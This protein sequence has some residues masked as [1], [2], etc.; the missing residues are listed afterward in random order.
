MRRD[1]S[2]WVPSNVDSGRLCPVAPSPGVS[3]V[4]NGVILAGVM[5]AAAAGAAVRVN[6][7]AASTSSR[8]LQQATSNQV[9]VGTGARWQMPAFNDGA[10]ES[11][12]GP[13]GFG[14]SF[15]TNLDSRMRTKAVSLYLRTPFVVDAGAAASTGTVWLT[16]DYDD[17]FV[18]ALNGN[19]ILRKNLG[20]P[21]A[22]VFRDQA[23]FNAHPMGTNVTVALGRS[24]DLFVTGTNW[25]TVQ[26]HNE[27]F[28][29]AD[30]G[31]SAAL[32][33]VDGVN[34]QSLLSATNVSRFWIGLGEP[35]GGVLAPA[36]NGTAGATGLEW[37]HRSFADSG[38]NQGPGGIGYGDGD[39]ATDVYAQMYGLAASLYM[40]RSFVVDAATAVSTNLLK[41]VIDYDDGYV[42]YLNGVEIARAGLGAAGEFVPYDAFATGR[43]AGTAVTLYPGVAAG[44]LVA[45]TNVLAIQVHN[46][47]L[48]STDLSLIADLYEGATN[49]LVNHADPW[50]YIVGEEPP[51]P[52]PDADAGAE[53]SEFADWIELH[54]DATNSVALT[55]W[56]LTD[57]PD[58]PRL[59]S[60]PDGAAIPARGYLVVRCTGLLAS[61]GPP[62]QASFKLDGGGEY[63]GLFNAAGAW[64]GGYT[65]GFPRQSYFHTYGWDTNRA[66]N[67]FWAVPTPGA[68]N[69]GPSFTNLVKDPDFDTPA[70]FYTNSLTVRLTNDT[71]GAEIRYTLDGSEP[72]TNNGVVYNPAGLSISSGVVVRARAFRA[73]WIPSR[74]I[75]RTYLANQP[76][77]LRSLP[78]LSLVGDAQG[79]IFKSNG[80]TSI[81]GGFW[82]RAVTSNSVT[83]GGLWYA[84]TPEDYN[85]P[86][87]YGRPYERPISFEFIEAGTTGSVYRTDCGLRVAGSAHA[88]PRYVL[89]NMSGTWYG[90]GIDNKPQMNLF[91]R[92]EYGEEPVEFP[93]IPGSRVDTFEGI[94]LRGGKNDYYNPFIRDE[95]TR[96]LLFDA[97]QVSSRGRMAGLYVNGRFRCYYNPCERLDQQFFQAWHRSTNEWDIINHAGVANGDS[98]AWNNLASKAT[99]LNTS[100]LSNYLTLAAL[101]D[102][103]SFADYIMVNTYGATWDWP[104]NNFY[105]ARERCSN[106]LFRFYIWD[107]EGA[108]SNSGGKTNGYDTIGRDLLSN[109]SVKIGA[110]FT[111]LY[112]SPEFK[113]LFADRFQKHVV[114]GPALTASN[115]LA[116]TMELKAELDPMMTYVRG[117]TVDIGNITNW[118]KV[119]SNYMVLHLRKYGLLPALAAPDFVT[120]GGEVT[121]GF[122][123]ALVST[124][125]G[126]QIYYALD[127]ADPRAVGGG[128]AGTLYTGPISIDRSRLIKA[129]CFDG[130]EWSAANEET[131]LSSQPPVVVTEIMYNPESSTGAEFIELFNA[132]NSPVDMSGFQFTRGVTFSFAGSAVSNLAPGEYCVVVE[133]AAV[134][135]L[136]YGTNGIRVA[137]TYSG[138]LDNGGESVELS[139]VAFGIIASFAYQDGWFPLTDGGGFSLTIR[140]AA[141]ETHL[142]DQKTS[143]RASSRY[144]GTPGGPDGG[145][146]PLPGAVVINEVLTHTDASPDGDWIELCNTTANPIDIGGWWISDNEGSPYKF[147][148]PSNTVLGGGAFAV[149]SASNHFQNAL[150]AAVPFGLSEFGE[151]VV[152]SSALDGAGHPTGYVESESFGAQEREVTF[153]R[154]I[155]ST[156]KADF[157]AMK[158]VTRGAANAGPRV[159]PVVIA[160]I[161]YL[162]GTNRA[163]FVK[164]YNL[165]P[166]NVPLWN[167][168]A[169]TQ[170]WQLANAITWN[171]PTGTVIAPYSSFVVC[172]TN[173]AAF[174]ASCALATNYPVFGPFTGSLNNAGDNLDL[175]KALDP[176]VTNLPYALVESVNYDD[177][178]PW[179]GMTVTGRSLERIALAGYGNEPLNW[180]MG[181]ATNGLPGP[182]PSADS[183][184]DGVPDRWEN[185]RGLDPLN[186]ADGSGDLDGDGLTAL[187]EFIA[188]TDP[189]S[190]ADYLRLDLAAGTNGQPV[191]TLQLRNAVDPGYEAYDRFYAIENAAD[192]PAHGWAGVPSA[193][194]IPA[195]GLSPYGF[196]DGSGGPANYRARVWLRPK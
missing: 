171:F 107:A 122:Q 160:E 45:G 48:T 147:R 24:A 8:L 19:E 123:V 70:G 74:T 133:N 53:S 149:F 1:G 135:A 120:P 47:S 116:R 51:V 134:F 196:T 40:R 142:L 63:L 9:Q 173:P 3:R 86:M 37:T 172:G 175:L 102:P 162:P 124:N 103:V 90:S 121:N 140:D 125:A 29:S 161:H 143:W 91:F 108:F 22:F 95:L 188:G 109:T 41:L 72:Q 7:V 33:L 35:S 58:K 187:A 118:V 84:S 94:R 148:I 106:G 42:A 155:K 18:A 99:A 151:S 130:V 156:G 144:G 100:V 177:E 170:T 166:S 141:A 146:V 81:V 114:R 69:A 152:L 185:P 65:N 184:G 15:A 192:L 186:A 78:A 28:D 128:I 66:T 27:A 76:V 183:D 32:S 38:W 132:G 113:L 191:V 12:R 138:K 88:R 82:S 44:L 115:V 20:T 55:G 16:C 36:T 127:G 54:N 17:G 112:K 57:D 26:I 176:D 46:A 31:W 117:T 34:S 168:A 101:V 39:D 163:E 96:R 105:A 180:R 194:N 21:G 129:R 49:L 126:G 43:E 178:A 5:L 167:T 179:P 182:M 64:V 98:V 56:S 14:A 30:F 131:Y 83:T 154:H 145:E 139:H 68:V 67:V 25:L 89:Q 77:A 52:E 150:Q 181:A 75:T 10:W 50:R 111:G 190:A 85:I 71:P 97:G 79:A 13:F 158:Q 157:V 6:E 169:P 153:G 165:T 4:R 110:V 60:F 104:Q 189:A 92:S 61:G 62:Y 193:T 174:R 2:A 159:G 73:G 80:V 137:G 87:K 195:T 59:W 11:T 93:F 119:R 136:R 23:A 164:L